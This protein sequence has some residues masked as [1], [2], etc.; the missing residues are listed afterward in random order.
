MSRKNKVLILGDSTID[1]RIWLG[2]EKY[3]LLV[4]FYLPFL[5]KVIDFLTW[6]NPFKPK[7]VVENLRAQMPNFDIID[8]TNDGFT[9]GDVLDGAYRDKVFGVGAHRFFPHE[10]FKPLEQDIEKADQI[11]ISVGGNNFRE[12][13]QTALRIKDDDRRKQYITEEYPNVF[14]K[15]QQ[16]YQAILKIIASRNP[17]ANLVLMTQYYP[18]LTQKTLLG[19]SIYEFMRELGHIRGLAT[20]QDTIVDV[21]KDSYNGIF[22]FIAEDQSLRNMKISVLD[23]TSSLNPNV[24]ENY[25]GQIEPSDQGGKQIAQMISHVIQKSNKKESAKKIYRFLPDYFTSGQKEAHVYTSALTENFHFSPVHPEKMTKPHYLS[26]YIVSTG[27][28]LALV[29]GALYLGSGLMT[30]SLLGLAGNALSYLKGNIRIGQ[31]KV[32]PKHYHFKE[33]EEKI[34]LQPEKHQDKA[35]RTLITRFST[36]GRQSNKPEV[37]TAVARRK[38]SLK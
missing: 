5:S 11:V 4:G 10:F 18:A 16:D 8:R 7:S 15:M 29:S 36:K 21:M 27:V 23:V 33:K 2:L 13:I 6:A 35:P 38:K 3:H 32:N 24:S 28:L 20:A 30:A 34:L 22:K 17:Q 12:F 26:Q 14:E 9:T 1:N 19:T 37:R 31:E 25:V